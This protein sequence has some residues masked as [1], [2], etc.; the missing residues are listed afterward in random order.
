MNCLKGSDKDP[1]KY[2]RI[3]D[4]AAAAKAKDSKS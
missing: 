3:I 2:L 4:D 1:A